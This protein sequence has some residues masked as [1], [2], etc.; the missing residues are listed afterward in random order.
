MVK[1]LKEFTPEFN[2]A[3]ANI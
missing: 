2:A 1:I 3:L